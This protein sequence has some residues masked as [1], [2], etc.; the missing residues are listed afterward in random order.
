M[1][2][3]IISLYVHKCTYQ[4]TCEHTCLNA[5]MRVYTLSNFIDYV[6]APS[7]SPC[8]GLDSHSFYLSLLCSP[9][10]HVKL[11]WQ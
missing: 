7:I 5:Y 10:W 9:D 8:L 3:G 2:I 1:I 11:T 4:H 6:P